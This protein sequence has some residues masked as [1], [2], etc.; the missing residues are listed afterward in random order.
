MMLP[1]LIS[2]CLA[3]IPRVTAQWKYGPAPSTE[4]SQVT[5]I[6]EATGFDG[7]KVNPINAST[8]EWW[9]FDAVQ[10]P[11]TSGEQAAVVISFYTGTADAFQLLA[12]YAELGYTSLA[13]VQTAVTWPNGTTQFFVVNATEAMIT[14]EGNGASGVFEEP[15]GRAS[16]TGNADM[17]VYEV[18]FDAE[19]I[20]GTVTLAST[21][22]AHYPCG[23]AVAGQDMQIA[24]HVGWANA[25]PAAAATVQ[26]VILGE[27]FEFTGIG[28]HDKN[29]GDKPFKS[30]VGTWYWG[31]GRLGDYTVAWFDF[32]TP[33][34]KNE[35]VSA[36]WAKDNEMLTAQCG[37]TVVRPIGNNDLFPPVMGTAAPDGFSISVAYP[38]QNIQGV[39]DLTARGNIIAEGEGYTRWV[40]RFEGMHNGEILTGEGVFEQFSFL[41]S[42]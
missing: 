27:A 14:A 33:D 25:I 8:W 1:F 2:L 21:A 6:S 36:Y 34:M 40:G 29:W 26:L 16:F 19:E 35:Y 5:W 30:S 37:R 13:L 7:P 38:E 39:I 4:N 10:V 42:D 18:S 24:P 15:G 23:P 3:L 12:P 20:S 11:T 17:S 28:Y 32:L 22:P 31:H 41:G 9:Y